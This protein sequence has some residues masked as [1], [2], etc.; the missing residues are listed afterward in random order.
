[1][2]EPDYRSFENKP[3]VGSYVDER[4]AKLR[5]E[6]RQWKKNKKRVWYL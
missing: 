4:Y 6:W 3:Q 1:M 2:S 5:D